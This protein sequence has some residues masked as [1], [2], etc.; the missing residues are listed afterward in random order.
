MP[1][2]E[3]VKNNIK[4]IKGAFLAYNSNID[5]IVHISKD[6]E[7]LWKYKP[8]KKLPNEIK[9]VDDFFAGLLY[10][11][12]KGEGLELRMNEEMQNWMAMNFIHREKRM[13]GQAGIM[14]NFL[15]SLGV[16]SIVFTPLLSRE[17]CSLFNDKVILLPRLK[18][19]KASARNDRKKTNWIFEFDEGEKLF[20]ITA[21]GKTRFI[22]ASRLDEYRL[23]NI[24]IPVGKIDFALFSGLQNIRNKYKDGTTYSDQL[25]IAEE[26]LRELKRNRKPV[27]IEF[28]FTKNEKI[29]RYMIRRI[30]PLVDSIGLDG[31]ELIDTL[32]LLKE[33]NLAEKVAR[34][35]IASVFLGLQKILKKSKT[36]K[37]HFHRK[38]YFLAVCRKDYLSNDEIKKSLEFATIATAAKAVGEIKCFDDIKNGLNVPISALGMKKMAELTR[39]LKKKGIAMRDGVA[40]TDDETI[41]IVPNRMAKESRHVVGLGDIV[42]ASIFLAENSYRI[43]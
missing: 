24:K 39:F 40:E 7:R 32:E 8:F 23:R 4:S 6:M 11:M 17:Q 35:D 26:T 2:L 43:K 42:S 34:D 14:A 31:P 38:G 21:K 20:G 27:H 22:A 5:S 37:V 41:I 29:K 16:Q 33:K 25:K 12:S 18:H 19:P 15:S 9:T 28:V 13:G 1:V 3:D 30:T 10:S 36:R